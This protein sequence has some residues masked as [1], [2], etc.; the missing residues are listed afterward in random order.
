MNTT[1]IKTDDLASLKS[2]LGRLI[3]YANYL[4]ENDRYYCF[5]FGVEVED[6]VISDFEV[7]GVV[8]TEHIFYLAED[9][10]KAFD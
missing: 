9:Y 2:A 1:Y 4:A 8:T 6:G 7:T 3:D 5:V 10:F